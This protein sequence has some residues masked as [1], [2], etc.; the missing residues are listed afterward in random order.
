MKIKVSLATAFLRLGIKIICRIDNREMS[1]LGEKGP[2]ILAINHINFLEVPL[3]QTQL[4]PRPMRGF[5]KRETWKNKFMAFFLD[6]YGAIPVD[7]GGSNLSA[8]RSAREALEAE[9]FICIAPEGTRSVTGQLLEG[10]PGIVHLA[11][12]TGAPIRPVVHYGGEL[13]WQNLKRLK[14]SR[15]TLKVGKPFYLKSP[16]KVTPEMRTIMTHE[17]M[18]QMAALLPREMRGFYADESGKSDRFLE[19]IQG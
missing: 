15:I 12:M 5:V 16:E 2:M 19:F 3:I 7:R 9:E 6:V 13:I 18:Y 1:A 10:K 11:L 17:I 4:Y 8:F 14:R